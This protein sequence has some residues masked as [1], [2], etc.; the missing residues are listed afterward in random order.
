M[1]CYFLPGCRLRS[2]H[3]SL[4]GHRLVEFSP[5]LPQTSRSK[6]SS[7]STTNYNREAKCSHE[8]CL[9]K[10]LSFPFSPSSLGL[11]HPRRRRGLAS[12][13]PQHQLPRLLAPQHRRQGR[14]LHRRPLS[15]PHPHPQ[16]PRSL[17]PGIL[18]LPPRPLPLEP[19]HLCLPPLQTRTS[20]G[21]RTRA[22]TR[23]CQ[24]RSAGSQSFRSRETTLGYHSKR[25]LVWPAP[26]CRGRMT[27]SLMKVLS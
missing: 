11:L 16:L 6:P 7:V 25:C 5:S 10:H 21:R 9:C 19:P 14:S 27:R 1:W 4:R 15:S 13:P 17:P 24:R 22:S 18:R 20:L 23:T 12:L 3:G 2:F 8:N 26:C